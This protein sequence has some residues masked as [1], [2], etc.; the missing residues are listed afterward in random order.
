[1]QTVQRFRTK[2]IQ[3]KKERNIKVEPVKTKIKAE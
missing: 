1:M 2:K 3:K